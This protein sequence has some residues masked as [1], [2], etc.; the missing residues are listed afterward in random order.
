MRSFRD[1]KN[2]QGGWWMPLFWLLVA[3]VVLFVLWYY[4]GGPE[5]ASSYQG[6]YLDAPAPIGTGQPYRR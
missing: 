6:L 5:R 4:T 1:P 2:T 3:F